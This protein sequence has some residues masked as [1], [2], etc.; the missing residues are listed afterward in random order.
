MRGLTPANKCSV[1]RIAGGKLGA[2]GISVSVVMAILGYAGPAAYASE[3]CLG[4][5]GC[6]SFPDTIVRTVPRAETATFDVYCPARAPYFWSWDVVA[7]KS[8]P[9]TRLT[10]VD[11]VKPLK[12]QS[13]RDNGL[14]LRIQNSDRERPAKVRIL[15][16]CS[17]EAF[18]YLGIIRHT[19]ATIR[20]GEPHERDEDDRR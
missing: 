7:A 19:A 5:R 20:A 3:E 9:P 18:P 14:R 10:D 11:L 4:V 1:G 17:N 13:G 2:V 8:T 16:G 12:D 15:L 6:V